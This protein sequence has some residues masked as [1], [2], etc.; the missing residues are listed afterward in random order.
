MDHESY[1]FTK[2][3]TP[4]LSAIVLGWLLRDGRKSPARMG[5]HGPSVMTFGR[6]F[7]GL[8]TIFGV[9]FPLFLCKVALDKGFTSLRAAC[10]FAVVF[11][12]FVAFG[13]TFLVRAAT[14]KVLLFDTGLEHHSIWSGHRKLRWC[15]I[16]EVEFS[17]LRHDLV[18]RSPSGI[19][20]RVSAYMSGFTTLIRRLRKHMPPGSCAQLVDDL[21]RNGIDLG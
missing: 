21:R 10:I 1:T 18:M 11:G 6:A 16:S 19:S 9:L 20:I 17:R 12:S 3:A 5:R 13:S 15:E 14:T 4:V 8:G 2:L 7:W